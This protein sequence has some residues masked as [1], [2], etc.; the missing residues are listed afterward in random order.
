MDEVGGVGEVDGVEE[1]ATLW[2]SFRHVLPSKKY[3]E[4][5]A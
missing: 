2:K 4:E 1:G 3:N 5:A